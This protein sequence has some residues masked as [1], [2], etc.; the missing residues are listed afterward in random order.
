M[1]SGIEQ[2][3]P[4]LT[5]TEQYMQMGSIAM[6]VIGVGHV[7]YGGL[8]KNNIKFDLKTQDTPLKFSKGD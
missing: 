3:R 2:L 6:G 1:S 4:Q 5:A 7:T 8:A